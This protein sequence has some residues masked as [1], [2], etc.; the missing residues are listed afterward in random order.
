MFSLHQMLHNISLFSVCE[1]RSHYKSTVLHY[2]VQAKNLNFNTN[3]LI[4]RT[5]VDG[6]PS[7]LPTVLPLTF[8]LESLSSCHLCT[9]QSLKLLRLIVYEIH[10][11]ENALYDLEH[12]DK[13]TQNIPQYPPL[14]M[15]YVHAKFEVA[16]CNSLRE[17][18]FT[19]KYN[20]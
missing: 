14:H 5:A 3:C 20:I 9:L 18:A 11:Q 12:G 2:P 7:Q 1:V 8:T 13:V 15:T 17:D 4:T 6:T 19:R 16:T 10:L